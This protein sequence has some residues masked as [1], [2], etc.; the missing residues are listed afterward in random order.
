L[1]LGAMTK[2]ADLSHWIKIGMSIM[3]I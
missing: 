1:R 2:I 3:V